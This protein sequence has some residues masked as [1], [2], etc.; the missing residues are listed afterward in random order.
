M[1]EKE[2][3]ITDTGYGWALLRLRGKQDPNSSVTIPVP[4]IARLTGAEF[5]T[6][7]EDCGLSRG[8]AAER[9]GVT[10]E[11]IKEY[12]LRTPDPRVAA[13]LV[14]LRGHIEKEAS[15]A[16]TNATA[17]LLLGI[18]SGKADENAGVGIPRFHP[19]DYHRSAY[20][21]KGYPYGV[22]IKIIARTADKLSRNGI[23]YRI[24]YAKSQTK[25]S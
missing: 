24:E 1:K 4:T 22:H 3:Q 21:Q 12:E 18:R 23:N 14:K 7:R 8:D 17:Q 25:T 16:A 6:L 5:R 2:D 9:F 20:A 10:A 11:K 19:A 13:Q 15:E